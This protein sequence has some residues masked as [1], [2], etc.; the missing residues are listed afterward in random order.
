V[1]GAGE[2]TGGANGSEGYG[3]LDWGSYGGPDCGAK[4]SEYGGTWP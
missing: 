4:G 1:G 2:S 3:L